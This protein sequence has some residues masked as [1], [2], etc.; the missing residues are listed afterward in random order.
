MKKWIFPWFP[1]DPD[2]Q[3]RL[4]LRMAVVGWFLAMLPICILV[5][6]NPHASTVTT[7]YH[8]ASGHWMSRG[9]LYDNTHPAT[10]FLYLPHF[11]ILFS[12]FH[13]LPVPAGEILWRLCSAAVLSTG[14]WRFVK[15]FFGE[16]A[17]RVFLWV[18]LLAVP[19]CVAAIRNGQANV[20]L[21]GVMLH[22]T[23][24]LGTKKWWSAA[25]FMVLALIAKPVI[26]A[27]ILLAL[28]VYRPLWLPMLLSLLALAVFP[29]FFAAPD[30]VLAQYR[31]FLTNL[32]SCAVAT[33]DDY[34][35][36]TGILQ[37]FHLQLSTPVSEI[38]R[39]FAGLLTLGL[40]WLGARR[41]REPMRAFWLLTLTAC[42]FM[43]F[44]PMNESNSYVI[45]APVMSIWT[46]HLL[47]RSWKNP[48]PWIIAFMVFS[49]GVLPNILRPWFRNKFAVFYHPLMTIVFLAMLIVWIWREKTAQPC[50]S[51]E[52]PD[53][54]IAIS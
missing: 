51:S 30:Y 11:A 1:P 28:V 33:G 48:L 18:M 4:F 15:Q 20:I 19:L 31:A 41:L 42:Y 32:S 29:F 6:H 44:N 47:D 54:R 35:D 8:D 16:A 3:N 24:S 25:A 2:F 14:I 7:Y 23:A 9:E 53:F 10:F 40:W 37:A 52:K 17:P 39:A 49:M 36:I 21:S 46:F 22:A 5:A 43:L 27:L 50:D 12:I 38:V 13:L 45:L 26:L 34:A